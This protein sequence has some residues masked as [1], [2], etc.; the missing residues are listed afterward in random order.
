MLI[1]CRLTF[2]M[3]DIRFLYQGWGFKVALSCDG[4][5]S[6]PSWAT[7]VTSRRRMHTEAIGSS[8]NAA[9]HWSLP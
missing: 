3:R 9:S 5:G 8:S 2:Y 1:R 4:L 7:I 6:R